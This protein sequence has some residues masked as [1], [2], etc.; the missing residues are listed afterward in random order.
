MLET[1]VSQRGAKLLYRTLLRES[2]ATCLANK[3]YTGL[4]S[5]ILLVACASTFGVAGQA[6]ANEAQVLRV[7]QGA[8]PRTVIVTDVDGTAGMTAASVARLN[9]VSKI[10]WAIGLGPIDDV[11]N[12]GLGAAG[13]P[14]GMRELVGRPPAELQLV[15]GRWP[16]SEAEAVVSLTAQRALGLSAEAGAVYSRSSNAAVVGSFAASGP[17]ADLNKLVLSGPR[18]GNTPAPV[19]RVYMVV[20]DVPSVEA[21]AGSVRGVIGAQNPRSVSVATSET[22]VLLQRAIAGNLSEF[23]RQVALLVLVIGMIL[24][25]IV[26]Y[27]AAAAKLR[28]FGRRRALG[29]SRSALVALVM[30]QSAL[31][32]LAGSVVGSLMGV[33]L[34]WQLSAVLPPLAF[35][36]SIPLLAI[37]TAIV[38]SVPAAL[39]AAFRDPVRIL[40]V[41]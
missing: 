23:S 19:D 22:L 38:A 17:L 12:V 15:S 21:T 1:T 3:L 33:A 8:G 5:G 14:N 7:L 39:L 35:S 6:A 37:V 32:S 25:A 2:W 27:A 34:V 29:A 31:P 10:G 40:R 20:T 9:A 28:D 26:M 13:L 36:V 41:P 11:R 16:V 24:V 30:L 4:V 18:R